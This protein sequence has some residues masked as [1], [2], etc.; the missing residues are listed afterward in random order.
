MPELGIKMTQRRANGEFSTKG[1]NQLEQK[2][3]DLLPESWRYEGLAV[4][5][6]CPDFW[7]GNSRVIEVFG[8]YWHR[9]DDPQAWIDHYAAHGYK[10]LVVWESEVKA[11][12][13]NKLLEFA[14][15]SL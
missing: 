14:N 10:C 12:Q 5:N 2:V 1:P 4:G 15:G 7:D 9:D 11:G 8:D 6:R 13:V 3:L